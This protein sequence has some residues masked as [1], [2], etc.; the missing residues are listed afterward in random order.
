MIALQRLNGQPFILNVNLI[1]TMESTPDTIIK[2]TNGKTLIVKNSIDDIVRKGIKYSQ[3]CNQSLQVI[4]R[5]E[6]SEENIN[7]K[8][9][10]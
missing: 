10:K 8:I 5:K 7:D 9:T 1:E 3:L 4:H 6:K 2:L